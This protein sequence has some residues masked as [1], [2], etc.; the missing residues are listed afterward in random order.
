MVQSYSD[1]RALDPS[2]YIDNV[3]P[4]R[5]ATIIIAAPNASLQSKAQADF[6]CDGIADDIEIQAAINLLTAGRT[7]KETVKCVGSFSISAALNLPSYTVLDLT[8]AEVTLANGAESYMVTISNAQDVDVIG[9]ILDGNSAGQVDPTLDGITIW[10]ACLRIGLRDIFLT[11]VKRN[12]IITWTNLA[13]NEDNVNIDNCAVTSCGGQGILFNDKTRYSTISNCYVAECTGQN[14]GIYG[15]YC[16]VSDTISYDPGANY[17]CFIVYGTGNVL[18]NCHAIGDGVA[19]QQEGFALHGGSGHQLV[20]CT[21]RNLT[22]RGV[23]I[24]D[25]SDCA[26]IECAIYDCVQSGIE[27]L[28][29]VG[30][31]TKRTR[32]I[33][34]HIYNCGMDVPVWAR[35]GYY[36]NIDIIIA[37]N[38]VDNGGI[39]VQSGK[40]VTIAGNIVRS[41]LFNAIFVTKQGGEANNTNV[42][43]TGNRGYK[44]PDIANNQVGLSADYVDVLLVKDNDFNGNTLGGIT[45]GAN[46]SDVTIGDN[47]AY[48]AMGEIRDTIANVL[49]ELGAVRGLWPFRDVGA[50]AT[51]WD[52]SRHF[53]NLTASENVEDF[54][55]PP[56]WIDRVTFYTFNGTDEY[57]S[58]ADAGHLF[59][60][61]N[62]AGNDDSAFSIILVI[63][64]DAAALTG[65]TLLAKY[66]ENTPSREWIVRIDPNGYPE[67]ELFD[68]SA[69]EYIGREDQTALTADALVI[70]IVTY[71]GSETSAGV[72]I[73]KDGVQVDDANHQSAGAYAAMEQLGPDLTALMNVV[74]GPLNGNFYTGAATWFAITG[75]ELSAD[76][77]W[78]VTQR[79]YGLMGA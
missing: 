21:V 31:G 38:V 55:I 22:G 52:L 65:A 76:E 66:D 30:T 32:I 74:A 67:V 18:T 1:F 20:N 70:L 17:D 50:T 64:P 44:H 2:K 40:D 34:N 9:G 24:L 19:V 4:G 69:N 46:L 3:S 62:A 37:N 45:L 13:V 54:D 16:T 47:K 68:E 14:I 78:L 58:R 28:G 39:L 10:H 57:L 63:S 25:V 12:G 29:S 26:V 15:D 6:I 56:A 48:V 7:W 71:D 5:G 33:G 60:F 53:R 42:V 43:I 77:A 73:Y 27:V 41:G 75:K 35:A 11:D 79:L 61:A 59:S 36:N 72:K 51:V 23:F 8:E 49:T